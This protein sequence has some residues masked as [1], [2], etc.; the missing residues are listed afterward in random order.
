MNIVKSLFSHTKNK[1][2]FYWIVIIMR[3]KPVKF[4]RGVSFGWVEKFISWKFLSWN[5]RRYHDERICKSMLV[6]CLRLLYSFLH[7]SHL[8]AVKVVTISNSIHFQ[9]ESKLFS[10][11]AA[12]KSQNAS[13]LSKRESLKVGYV[14]T[15]KQ[16]GRTE[17]RNLATW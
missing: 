16:I 4:A 5:S 9:S 11:M 2:H 14:V 10:P 17:L 3:Y 1:C 8:G 12:D 15:A 13:K 7:V 6:V